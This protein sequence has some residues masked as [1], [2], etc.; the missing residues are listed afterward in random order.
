MA[1]DERKHAITMRV[2]TGT[3]RGRR[4]EA[5]PGL[6]TRPTAARVKEA[7]FSIIQ[8]EVEGARVL[9]LFAGSGQMGIEALSRGAQAC[10]FV[11]SAKAC[12]EII[13]ENLR[14]AGLSDKGRVVGT[15][16]LSYL[17]TQRG[18]FDIVFLD[19][20]YTEG[21]FP[22]LLAALAPQ[23]SESGV[24]LCETARADELPQT[25]GTLSKHREYRYGKTKVT[26]YRQEAIEDSDN[27]TIEN[28]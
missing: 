4:L 26:V 28:N 10:A 16:A 20:P 7:V 1:I 11:D 2:I 6:N 27:P 21:G 22:K 23:M 3:A 18:P 5:P 13:R 15:D 24:V 17:Q 8:F 9:D 14:R 12:H 25:A 19:P